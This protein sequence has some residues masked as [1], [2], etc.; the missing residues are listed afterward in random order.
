MAANTAT[1]NAARNT[2]R[3]AAKRPAAKT[4]RITNR[5]VGVLS[6]AA[7]VSVILVGNGLTVPGAALGLAVYLITTGKGPKLGSRPN[8][9]PAIRALCWGA[10]LLVVIASLKGTEAPG[11]P[12]FGFALAAALVTA[13]SLTGTRKPRKR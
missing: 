11:G 9:V 7:A 2:K 4:V 12:V 5:G 13:L 3:N 8:V 1:R 10:T 6:L